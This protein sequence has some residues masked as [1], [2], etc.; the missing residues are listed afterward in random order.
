[1]FTTHSRVMFTSDDRVISLKAGLDLEMPGPRDRRVNAVI[2]AVHTGLLD[3]T[4]L[5]EAV[6]NILRIIFKAAKTPKGGSFD[7]TGHHALARR[8][9]AEGMV[10]LKN[11]GILPLK[12]R[13]Q[14]AV[15]GLSAK[16]PY[17]QGGQ[18]S[19]QPYQAEYPI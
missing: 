13:K 11:N 12:S 16:K 2:E 7:I 18:L 14:I 5:D 19:H 10:L 9:A 15:I 8:I 4:V 17:Y 1:M 6:G 3:E